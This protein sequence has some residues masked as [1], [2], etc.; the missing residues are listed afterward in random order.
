MRTSYWVI[1]TTDKLFN[2]EDY[3]QTAEQLIEAIADILAHAG[4]VYQL[5]HTTPGQLQDCKTEVHVSRY[6]ST[7]DGSMSKICA[8]GLVDIDADFE[9]KLDKTKLSNL[10]RSKLPFAVKV[11]KQ[12]VKDR[13]E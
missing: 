9:V 4:T 6:G 7:E 2:K 8:R 1:V 12:A 3:Y 10:I 5:T 11:Q 13:E